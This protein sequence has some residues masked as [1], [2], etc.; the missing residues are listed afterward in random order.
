MSVGHRYQDKTFGIIWNVVGKI[1]HGVKLQ[2]ESKY[3]NGVMLEATRIIV[4]W[5]FGKSRNKK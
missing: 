5:Y 2:A 1:P 3:G 4:K